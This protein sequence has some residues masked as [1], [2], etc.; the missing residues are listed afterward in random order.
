[1]NIKFNGEILEVSQDKSLL[2]LLDEMN[3]NTTYSAVAVN[4]QVIQKSVQSSFYP[5]ENDV[6]EVL[7]PM[8]GG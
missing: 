2:N 1:M 3:M 5:K 7:T 4:N 6:V 8:Q